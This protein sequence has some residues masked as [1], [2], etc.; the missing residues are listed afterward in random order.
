MS[1][2]EVSYK[3]EEEMGW[4]WDAIKLCMNAGGND[5]AY[6]LLLIGL[7]GGDKGGDNISEIS[8]R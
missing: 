1:K 5:E 4:G 6:I 8:S 2:E 3:H 7:M